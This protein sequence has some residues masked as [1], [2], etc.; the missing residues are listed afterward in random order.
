PEGRRSTD[1]CAN[2]GRE[3]PACRPP[4]NQLVDEDGHAGQGRMPMKT[5]DRVKLL[6]GPYR[7]PPLKG[8]GRAFCLFR[9]CLVVVTSWTDARIPW[10]RCR[11][12]DNPLG[13]SGLL[14]DEVLA[15]A[16]QHESAA[17]I[18]FWWRPS[19]GAVWRWRK[20]LGVTRTSSAGSRRL[21]QAAAKAGAF[22]VQ[23]RE[24]TDEERDRLSRRARDLGR[25]RDLRPRYH[26]PAWTAEEVALLGQLPDAE[27]A[28]RT[29]RT[30]EAVRQKRNEL[31]VPDPAA[32][33]GAY[34][35]PPWSPDED[36]LVRRLRPA[37]A[38]AKAGRTMDAVY[39]RRHRLGA[40]HCRGR[41]RAARP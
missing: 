19:E 26:G 22:A 33:R 2:A 13:G 40:T 36:A 37:D 6:F 5:S 17:A 27:V 8:G 7:A 31:G 30:R 3:R 10:P 11:P 15:W 28:E 38:A 1:C 23:E 24:V 20:A 21:I 9:D 18:C 14:V 12:L 39:G 29:G 25:D 35:A 16:I 4:S 41:R 34:G 32:R